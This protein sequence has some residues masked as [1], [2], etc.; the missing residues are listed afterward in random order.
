MKKSRKRS[1]AACGGGLRRYFYLFQ[2]GP[3]L[4]GTDRDPAPF[5]DAP[6]S[7]RRTA[8]RREASTPFARDRRAGLLGGRRDDVDALRHV[9]D[10][11]AAV[12][13]AGAARGHV[14]GARGVKTQFLR[15]FGVVF[16]VVRGQ[17]VARRCQSCRRRVRRGL[18]GPSSTSTAFPRRS[19]TSRRRASASRPQTGEVAKRARGSTSAPRSRSPRVVRAFTVLAATPGASSDVGIAKSRPLRAFLSLF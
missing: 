14:R 13:A 7:S 8:G 1:P 11:C 6:T 12:G 2:P 3:R 4:I 9:P 10:V 15:L 18:P 5:R 19:T 16:G 17:S